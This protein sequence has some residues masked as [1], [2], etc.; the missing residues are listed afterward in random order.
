MDVM[1]RQLHRLSATFRI[2]LHPSKVQDVL[3]GVKELLNALLL[4]YVN[5]LAWSS[6]RSCWRPSSCTA[7]HWQRYA[8][9]LWHLPVPAATTMI[10]MVCCSRTAASRS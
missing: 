4:R 5:V 7:N 3:G 8:Y 1:D 2:D 6:S 10:L 9:T